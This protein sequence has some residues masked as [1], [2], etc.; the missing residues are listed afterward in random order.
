MF[1]EECE[2]TENIKISEDKYLLKVKSEKSFKYAEAGQFF[3]LKC[4]TYLRRPISV[5]Y[6][7]KNILEFYYQ[8]K[9][10]GTKYLSNL[11]IADTLNIQGP[12]GKGFKTDIENKNLLIVAGGMGIAP[13]KLLINNLKERN[14]I[15]L[16]FG[17]ANEESVKIIEMFDTGDIKLH[18]T[19]ED[20]SV[21]D[22]CN[23]VYKTKE[24]LKENKFD[25]IYAC[26]PEIMIN[27]VIKLALEN[28]IECFA[29]LERRMACGI[30]ACLGCSI[31][32]F[33]IIKNKRILKKVCHDGPVFDARYLNI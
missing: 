24:L 6:I 14:N 21:G 30:N 12:L 27:K 11:K 18:I 7:D 32:I 4:D 1:L 2:I 33:D 15:S 8:V 29:S 19:T 5:H 28:D 25:L 22:K 3:M 23:S 20:G 31:E 13:F 9:G 16:I 17:G 10:E 26:G